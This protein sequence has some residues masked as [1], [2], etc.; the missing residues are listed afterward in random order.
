M[1]NSEKWKRK[2]ETKQNKNEKKN[3]FNDP[4]IVEQT[5]VRCEFTTAQLTFAHI[6]DL[7]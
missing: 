6:R 1:L 5:F 3:V 7:D 2:K 4:F